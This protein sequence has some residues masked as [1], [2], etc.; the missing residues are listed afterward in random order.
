MVKIVNRSLTLDSDNPIFEV[1]QD[2]QRL[3]D[4]EVDSFENFVR[5]LIGYVDPVY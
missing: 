3:S 2:R 4:D 1:A 5:Y